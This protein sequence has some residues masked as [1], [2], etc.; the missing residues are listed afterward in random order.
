M[1]ET[2]RFCDVAGVFYTGDA[3]EVSLPERWPERTCDAVWGA[4]RT[5]GGTGSPGRVG[6]RKARISWR[7]SP[8][9]GDSVYAPARGCCQIEDL[10]VSWHS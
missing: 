3:V 6:K 4:G 9:L 10:V 2:D 7:C 8:L 1:L 5:Y